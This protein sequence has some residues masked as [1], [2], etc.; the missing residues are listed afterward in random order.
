MEALAALGVA[1][2]VMQVLSCGHE[3]FSLCKRLFRTG[4]AG[5]GLRENAEAMRS[6]STTLQKSL[7]IL[8]QPAT[9][10]EHELL[11]IADA[12][13]TS[14]TE[15]VAELEKASGGST[16]GKWGAAI[17]SA[18]KMKLRIGHIEQLEKKMQQCQ[19]TLESG[20]LL[21]ICT[22]ADASAVRN[23]ADFETLDSKLQQF[24][25]AYS[26]GHI[27]LSSLIT[28][29]KTQLSTEFARV[30]DQATRTRLLKS[31]KYEGMNE[32]R[33]TV[34]NNHEGT[35]QW[36]FA[37]PG[38]SPSPPGS[39]ASTSQ[40]SNTSRW[41]SFPDW[42]RS[43]GKVYWVSGKAGSGKSTLMSFLIHDT[44]SHESLQNWRSSTRII[45]HFLWSSGR[46]VQKSIKG[47]LCSLLHQ[48]LSSDAK[49][50]DYV[51]QQFPASHAKDDDTDW[52]ELELESVLVQA[53]STASHATCVFI[54]GLD[55]IIPSDG[56]FK[57]IELVWRLQKVPNIKLC[58]SG[59]PEPAFERQFSQLPKLRLQD[60]TKRDIDR[61]VRA[62]MDPYLSS[63]PEV[64][65][66][67][68]E[69]FV[70]QLCWKADGVFLWLRL[71]LNS[72]QKGFA[73]GDSLDLLQRRLDKL[74]GD[75][76]E[77][78]KD[79]WRRLG[80]DAE[81]YRV[82]AAKYFNFVLQNGSMVDPRW[83][84]TGQNG[85]RVL[86]LMIA[87]DSQAGNVVL[88]PKG[89]F[90]D[91]YL[92]RKCETVV[93]H[94]QTRCAG[95]LEC[96]PG[97]DFDN[98]VSRTL[99]DFNLMQVRFIHRSA[100]D[101]LISSTEGT[102]ILSHDHSN[103]DERLIQ[104]LRVYL[105]LA[106]LY[107]AGN[108]KY[109]DRWEKQPSPRAHNWFEKL[110]YKNPH[111]SSP[112]YT[113]SHNFKKLVWLAYQVGWR[114][115]TDSLSVE[116]SSLQDPSLQGRRNRDFM[117][118]WIATGLR[119]FRPLVSNVSR[120]SKITNSDF[121][122]FAIHSMICDAPLVQW[123]V[124]E[125][126]KILQ[127]IEL[128]LLEDKTGLRKRF[129]TMD[130]VIGQHLPNLFTQTDAE[131]ESPSM[132]YPVSLIMLLAFKMVDCHL[133]DPAMGFLIGVLAKVL[134]NE[135]IVLEEE[136]LVCWRSGRS[137]HLC[138]LSGEPE[139]QDLLSSKR[140]VSGYL[141]HRWA[142][143]SLPSGH[144]VGIVLEEW[145]KHYD[146]VTGFNTYP[147][148]RKTAEAC[149]RR[150]NAGAGFEKPRL[151]WV[152]KGNG[153][154]KPRAPSQRVNAARD[155][156]SVE[157]NPRSLSLGYSDGEGVYPFFQ[158]LYHNRIWQVD[159][160]EEDPQ[161][162]E[163]SSADEFVADM[164]R[165]P[166]RLVPAEECIR[167]TPTISSGAIDAL[168]REY[169]GEAAVRD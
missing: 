27:E 74:P 11:K 123:G 91:E 41:S 18:L 168:M 98:G 84:P 28:T 46:P 120:H 14:S 128:P 5:H 164:C 103:A 69:R 22:L 53:I 1:C 42:L 138:L 166:G 110:G 162:L 139:I 152:R 102:E 66:P 55:E 58:V 163:L 25:V 88:D 9:E 93:N 12:C 2:N 122:V 54:D 151:L 6:L 96:G 127:E 10:A 141:G 63:I 82:T 155:S 86:S 7:A 158:V 142:V 130:A 169:C 94:I 154:W 76:S 51:L 156:G 92:I 105:V 43:D 116:P 38:T 23:R 32:R 117:R 144:L 100:R 124:N 132:L 121:R 118:I 13:L 108:L 15:L 30:H 87:T 157:G 115:V 159:D 19:Q 125:Y 29:V 111:F 24:I 160:W 50:L 40:H 8:P 20:L 95:L 167:N 112:T 165:T 148:L 101:F 61:Y 83:T 149:L 135:N 153:L 72:M 4:D 36:I 133:Y 99:D 134:A 143:L 106:Y 90:S 3:L 56:P 73:N 131:E 47:L 64:L 113:E 109:Q 146:M 62:I 97:V 16:K 126:F 17:G 107:N 35:F 44:R 34:A 26:N 39:N 33:N 37:D 79:M 70:D 161:D 85:L 68:Y 119:I 52:S 136:C 80:E 77:L 137:A 48:L 150:L 59:R 57:I 65:Y 31:L 114:G 71:V 89:N 81:F 78:F 21:R 147:G 67:A 129:A 45:A 140:I 60:L 75:I 145:V 104:L 49:A